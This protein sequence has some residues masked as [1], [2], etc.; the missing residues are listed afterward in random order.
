MNNSVFLI[1]FSI[2]FQHIVSNFPPIT[3]ACQ[4][5]LSSK[6]DSLLDWESGDIFLEI[7]NFLI[8]KYDKSLKKRWNWE[9]NLL[10][11]NYILLNNRINICMYIYKNI[12]F[13]KEVTDWLATNKSNFG[14]K[15][16]NINTLI[17]VLFV[18]NLAGNSFAD[19][20]IGA[21]G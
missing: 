13:D 1:S 19:E 9:K 5:Q 14:S 8:L 12:T 16:W 15:A 18:W 21:S 11:K 10:G 6:N 3:F 20:F 7:P 4:R 17:L 2:K